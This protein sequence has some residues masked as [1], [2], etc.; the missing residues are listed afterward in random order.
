MDQYLVTVFLILKKAYDTTCHYG[1]H[2]VLS[3]WNVRDP[4]SH[5]LSNLPQ[6]HYFLVVLSNGFSTLYLQ[7]NGIPQGLVLSVTLFTI[8]I[9]GMV[10]VTQ[11]HSVLTARL[12]SSWSI[13]TILHIL[14]SCPFADKE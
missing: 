2:M 14:I 5:F 11:H 10:D 12:C 3:W 8:T 7:E 1:M 4:L 9:S 13:I 6:D